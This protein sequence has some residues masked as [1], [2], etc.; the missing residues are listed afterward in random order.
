MFRESNPKIDVYVG[1]VYKGSTNWS[2]TCK[3]AKKKYLDKN[4]TVNPDIVKCKIGK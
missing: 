4:P 2:R 1:G 3:E